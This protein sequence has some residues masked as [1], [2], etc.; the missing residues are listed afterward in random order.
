MSNAYVIV[1]NCSTGSQ[2]FFSQ[3]GRGYRWVTN[4][5]NAT[6]FDSEGAAQ[7]VLEDM[8]SRTPTLLLNVEP[9][10]N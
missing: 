3:V 1:L 8:K 7:E 6:P 9:L 5:A 2:K 4:T 10:T